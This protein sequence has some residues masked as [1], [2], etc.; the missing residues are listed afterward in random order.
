MKTYPI[1]DKGAEILHELI[2]ELMA[3]RCFYNCLAIENEFDG[4]QK[5]MDFFLSKSRATIYENERLCNFLVLR[6]I[7][8]EYEQDDEKEKERPKIKFTGLLSG[9]NMALD[10]ELECT[11]NTEIAIREMFA[12]DMM[13]YEEIRGMITTQRYVIEE[14][15]KMLKSLGD[16]GE[17]MDEKM[18]ESM[19]FYS[20]VAKEIIG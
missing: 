18:M 13:G 8:P 16:N 6:G 14:Y 17:G 2:E 20:E 12:I 9:M 1:S 3:K 7:K 10:Y 4:Y 11:E 15:T 5:A 19:M